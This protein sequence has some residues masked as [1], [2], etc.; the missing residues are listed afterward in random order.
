MI[1]NHRNGT[2]VDPHGPHQF[3]AVLLGM[4]RSV[5]T[6]SGRDCSIFTKRIGSVLRID[7]RIVGTLLQESAD[8]RAVDCRVI[9]YQYVCHAAHPSSVEKGW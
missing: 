7:D 6:T 5:T 9:Y 8:D 1:E 4:F 2:E 3:Q